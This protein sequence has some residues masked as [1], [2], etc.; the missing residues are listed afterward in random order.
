MIAGALTWRGRR[1]SVLLGP[2][3]DRVARYLDHMTRHGRV[4]LRTVDL[5]TS[6]GVE[7]SEVYRITRRLRE[8]GLFGVEN[9][10]GGTK[11]GRRYWRTLNDRDGSPRLDAERHRIAWSRIVAWARARRLSVA[12]RLGELHTPRSVTRPV[13]AR[14]GSEAPTVDSPSLSPGPVAVGASFREMFAAAGGAALLDA[15][16]A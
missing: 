8:L 10:Q 12:A 3:E 2:T 5:V 9:D 13:P 6:L 11:G 7:R 4:T 15:W 14:I 16:R 1:G